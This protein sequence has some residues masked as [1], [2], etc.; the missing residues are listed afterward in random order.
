[1]NTSHPSDNDNVFAAVVERTTLLVL[2]EFQ[3]RGHVLLLPSAKKSIWP[4]WLPSLGRLLKL[5]STVE[6]LNRPY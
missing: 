1:M 2:D 6:V 4:A 3:Q 5:A